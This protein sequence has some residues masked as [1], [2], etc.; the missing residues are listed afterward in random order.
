MLLVCVHTYVKSI[1][2]YKY[3]I[4][5]TCRPYTLYLYEQECE[6]PRLFFETKKYPQAK[7]V[8]EKQT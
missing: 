7:N 1:L 5:D 2:R 4:L 3:L 6:D 8:W